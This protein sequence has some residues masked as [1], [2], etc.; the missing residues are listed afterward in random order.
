MHRKK[1]SIDLV[2][3][4][5]GDPSRRAIVKK[6]SH[7]PMSVS[8]LAEPLVITLAAVI[9]HLQVLEESGLVHTE[10]TGRVRTCRIE[11]GRAFRG[12]AM[13]RRTPLDL[14][15]PAR[16]AGRSAGRAGREIVVY[17]GICA[18]HLNDLKFALRSLARTKGLT[19]TV[20]LTLA[21]GIGANAAIFS[22]VRGVLLRPL[23][24]RDEERLVYIR[25]SAP[26]PR[27]RQRR[28]LGSGNS[29]PAAR[30]KTICAFGDFSTI[31]FTMVGL[32]DPREVRAGVVGGSYFEVM[33][34]RPVLGRL[35]DARDDGPERG[36]GRGAD[37]PLLDHGAEERSVRARQ[38]DSSRH[39]LGHDHRRA[40]AV[41]SVSGR[42]RDHR[43]RRHQP[44]PPVGDHGDRARP[45]HDRAL[46]PPRAGR[47]RSKRRAPSCAPCTPSMVKEHPESYSP[48]A[49]FR[50]DAVRCATRSRRVPGPCCSCCWRPRRWCSSSPART[51]PT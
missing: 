25:Q 24:N 21:L 28:V 29:R 30:V 38:I 20:V 12:G 49:D 27:R 31:G 16:P 2:F 7:G 5:L 51:S 9:Q 43:Q 13:D 15:A 42:N 1:P 3:H 47:R 48:K 33:G 4:A 26:R 40:G 23:V 18:M 22:L 35:L 11:A 6:L 34:L 41:R 19:I 46:R 44:A 45:S 14:G 8:Q 50:I 32:G 17:E 36:G 39:A 10:K 37:L